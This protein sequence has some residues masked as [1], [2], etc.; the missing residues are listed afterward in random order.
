MLGLTLAEAIKSD[1]LQE[2][3]AQEEARGIGH[4]NRRDVEAAIKT[5]ATTPTQSGNPTSPRYRTAIDVQAGRLRARKSHSAKLQPMLTPS[6]SSKAGHT[7][8][9]TTR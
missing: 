3:I 8:T 4:A 7:P 9:G 2:F 6:A 5:L 1:R